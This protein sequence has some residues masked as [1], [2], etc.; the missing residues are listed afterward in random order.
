[1][2]ATG[3]DASAYREYLTAVGERL[4]SKGFSERDDSPENYDATVFHRRKVSIKKLGYVDTF[5]VVARFDSA[6]PDRAEA[7]SKAAFEYG[8]ANKSLFPRIIGTALVVYPVVVGERFDDALLDWV[9]SYRNNHLSAYEFPVAVDPTHGRTFYNPSKSFMGWIHYGDFQQF[10]DEQIGP[11]GG[12][13]GGASDTSDPDV[14]VN[15]CPSCGSETAPDAKFCGS[16]G[17]EL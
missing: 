16:C 1:M 8:L 11:V 14:Q 9:G 2:Q 7:F 17:T 15:Y 4:R 3:T 5:V 10:A 12:T 13:S 6:T